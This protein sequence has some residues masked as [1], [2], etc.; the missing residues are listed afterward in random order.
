MKTA[1]IVQVRAQHPREWARLAR[2]PDD[3]HRT[4]HT[5][6]RAVCEPAGGLFEN[7]ALVKVRCVQLRPA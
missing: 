7:H 1:D 3:W 6:G 4:V 5:Q 2:A